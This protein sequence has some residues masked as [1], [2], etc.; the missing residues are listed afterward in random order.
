MKKKILALIPTRLNSKRLP[1]KALLPIN[2]LPLIIHVYNR[3]LLS[4]KL[5]K[6]IICCDDKKIFDICKKYDANV[7]MTSKSHLNG[8]DRI[9]EAYSKL[10]TKY[11]LVVDIQGDEPPIDPNHIDRVIN[12]HLKNIHTDIILPHLNVRPLNNSNIVKLVTNKN[13]EVIYI[14][15]ANLPFEFNKKN[16]F[17]KKH[18]SIISFQPNSLLKFGKSKISQLELIEDIE[19][20]RAINIGLKIKTINLNGDSFSVDVIDD[21]KK[22]QKKIKRDKYFKIYKQKYN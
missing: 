6:V 11:D 20:L 21:Y 13:D 5:N 3:S 19:L 15:R 17:L 1:A 2:G 14:S 12:Y 10:K 7:M 8:T 16:M 4:K 22:A 18:L 9:C